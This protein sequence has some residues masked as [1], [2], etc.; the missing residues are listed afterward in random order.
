MAGRVIREKQLRS[1]F[2]SAFVVIEDSELLDDEKNEY[3]EFLDSLYEG[4][5]ELLESSPTGSGVWK[6]ETINGFPQATC[7]LCGFHDESAFIYKYCPKYG[8]QM[9]RT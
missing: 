6:E 5:Y 1:F 9:C 2:N 8:A 7:S 4:L 3:A